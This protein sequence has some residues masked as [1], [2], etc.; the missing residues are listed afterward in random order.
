MNYDGMIVVSGPACSGKSTFAASFAS[1]LSL[2]LV[3]HDDV[4]TEIK[5]NSDRNPNDRLQACVAMHQRA[6]VLNA[7]GQGVLL[8]GTY[9]RRAYRADLLRVFP[10]TSFIIIEMRVPVDVVLQ[11]F[12]TRKGHPGIDL[13][14]ESVR[15]LV[16]TYPY[17]DSAITIDGTLSYVEQ[18][19]IAL[20]AI[21]MYIHRTFLN[22]KSLVLTLA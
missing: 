5:P 17:W 16:S 20:D 14:A 11:R 8:E 13:T 22:G 18:E 10:A 9:S 2:E 15:K 1:K 6:C 3:N 19:R 4:L 21:K 12:D 7:A